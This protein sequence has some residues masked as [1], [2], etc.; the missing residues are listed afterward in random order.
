MQTESISDKRMGHKSNLFPIFSYFL[1]FIEI[2]NPKIC[3]VHLAVVINTGLSKNHHLNVVERFA[4]PFDP[5]LS[6]AI[7]PGRV[8]QVSGLLAL[9]T[10]SRDVEHHLSGCRR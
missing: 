6:G 8:S 7:A 5:V 10:G 1:S 4:C 9:Q 3:E 2:H